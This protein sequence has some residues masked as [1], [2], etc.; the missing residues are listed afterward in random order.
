MDMK[1]ESVLLKGASDP[2]FSFTIENGSGTTTSSEQA[3][4]GMQYWGSGRRAG[5][6]FMRGGSDNASMVFTTNYNTAAMTIGFDGNVGNVG[7]GI[8]SDAT[9]KLKVAGSTAN[10]TAVWANYSDARLK[11]NIVNIDSALI[12]VSKLRPVEFEF[13]DT[14]KPG[15]RWGFIAQEVEQVVPKWV[16]QDEAGMKMLEL[17]GMNAMLVKTVQELTDKIIKLESSK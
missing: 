2:S 17:E 6:S 5:I 7:I 12:T 14:S 3:W 16:K 9:Y 10:T 13:I 8:T 15:K 11:K 1:L 4:I